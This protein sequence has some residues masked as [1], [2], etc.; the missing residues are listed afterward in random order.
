MCTKLMDGGGY[1]DS[2]FVFLSR[3]DWLPGIDRQF[4]IV[5]CPRND[6]GS[7]ADRNNVRYTIYTTIKLK[8]LLMSR[9]ANDITQQMVYLV[10][11]SWF[12]RYISH[13][14]LNILQNF[15]EVLIVLYDRKNIFQLI[16]LLFHFIFFS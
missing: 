8:A 1:G 7:R 12:H 2:Q 4:K 11:H 9:I 15:T 16:I 6:P 13:S 10:T 3:V 5:E 14:R